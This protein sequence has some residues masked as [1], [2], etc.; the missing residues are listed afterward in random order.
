MAR[1]A[2]CR[3]LFIVA[4]AALVATIATL[5]TV[6][7]AGA[8][9]TLDYLLKQQNIDPDTVLKRE[10]GLRQVFRRDLRCYEYLCVY[11]VWRC[12]ECDGKPCRLAYRHTPNQGK[13]VYV[14][15]K[16][17]ALEETPGKTVSVKEHFLVKAATETRPINPSGFEYLIYPDHSSD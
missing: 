2:S 9:M 1:C 6:A 8:V 11:E 17:I 5:P 7:H 15:E 13:P 4:A 14:A 10:V 16:T 3:P 12:S